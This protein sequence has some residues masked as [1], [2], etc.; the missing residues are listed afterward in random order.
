MINALHSNRVH[1]GGKATAFAFMTQ[2]PFNQNNTFSKKC[3]YVI[4]GISQGNV[5]HLSNGFFCNYVA[6]S[7]IPNYSI[8]NNNTIYI[9]AFVFV[10][11]VCLLLYYCVERKNKSHGE[12]QRILINWEGVLNADYL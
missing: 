10:Y 7:P 9:I 11:D 8:D 3:F 12:H 6:F 2:M 1:S 5:Y 4:G